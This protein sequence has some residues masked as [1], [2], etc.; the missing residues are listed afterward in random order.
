[1]SKID[2][3]KY[4][5][6]TIAKLRAETYQ[7]FAHLF[8]KELS[9]DE[10]K[11]Y[12]EGALNTLFEMFSEIGLALEVDVCKASIQQLCKLEHSEIE[13][14][15]D[16]ASCFLL[17]E[18]NGANPYASL[19]LGGGMMYAES[20]RKMRELLSKSGLTILESFKEPSDH[21]AIYL[22]L[23]ERWCDQFQREL[24]KVEDTHA[25][26][27]NELIAQQSFIENGL[28]SWLHDWN[29]R[30]HRISN[31][32]TAFYQ[33]MGNLLVAYITA[34]NDYLISEIELLQSMT[35]E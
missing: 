26:I 35:S 3:I 31:C 20:E 9:N 30:L 12:Q 17:D 14:R 34:D 18:K 24:P 4:E 6:L 22:S 28:L 27:L 8:A 1:M 33:A 13:L 29:L 15:G 5:A 21:L 2:Q 32:K 25:Y 16:F 23:I 19:Y 7:W 10:C 11:L